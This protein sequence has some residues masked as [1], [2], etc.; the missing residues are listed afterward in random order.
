MLVTV[1]KWTSPFGFDSFKDSG[2][3]LDFV[4]SRMYNNM[5]MLKIKLQENDGLSFYFV[6][7]QLSRK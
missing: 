7:K 1:Q 3:G 2:L 4:L 5:E 6:Q